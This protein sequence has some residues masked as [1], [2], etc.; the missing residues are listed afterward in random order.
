MRIRLLLTALAVAPLLAHC[1]GDDL[2]KI[3]PSDKVTTS[4]RDAAQAA[5]L[6]SEYRKSRG[7]GP[8][9]A[10][11]ALNGA[12]EHQARA[13]AEAGRL[14]HGAFASRME[15][16]KIGGY[17]A[18]NLSAGS[19]TVAGAIARWKASPGHNENL[20]MPQARRIGLARADS[21]QHGYRHYWALVLAQ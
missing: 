19:D 17:S 3:V 5:A 8:V 13:V 10:D 16:F 6:I 18:E 1:A 14:S 12:A 4:T 15:S 21:P 9:T 11:P 7:L 20:L 2:T